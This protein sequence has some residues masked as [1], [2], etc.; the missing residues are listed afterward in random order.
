MR[1][2]AGRVYRISAEEVRQSEKYEE[3]GELQDQMGMTEP[4]EQGDV[5]TY[6][7]QLIDGNHRAAAALALGEPSIWVYVAENSMANV[8]KKDLR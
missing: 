4:W 2:P 8:R 5:G 6:Y 3:R 1:L 7:A